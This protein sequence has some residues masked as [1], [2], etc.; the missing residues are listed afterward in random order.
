MNSDNTM[1]AGRTID[2]GPFGVGIYLFINLCMYVCMYV[3]RS[4]CMYVVN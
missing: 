4:I 2:Y 3:C 1:L